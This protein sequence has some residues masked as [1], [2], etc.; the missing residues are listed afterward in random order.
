MSECMKE[1]AGGYMI[2][3]PYNN[4]DSDGATVVVV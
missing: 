3:L 2:A 4:S 1:K